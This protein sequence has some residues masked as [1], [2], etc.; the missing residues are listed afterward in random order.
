[1][2]YTIAEMEAIFN[3]ISDS[4]DWKNKIDSVILASERELATDAIEFYTATKAE[5]KDLGTKYLRV[6]ATGYRNGPA[7]P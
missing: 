6:F 3:K 1:M 4:S 7:G 2:R 5:F